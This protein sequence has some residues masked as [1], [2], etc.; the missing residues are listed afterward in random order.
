MALHPAAARK[1]EKIVA[2][3]HG[4]IQV[5]KVEPVALSI[6]R[7]RARNATASRSL[8]LNCC[9]VRNFSLC[10]YSQRK[11]HKDKCQSGKCDA[12]NHSY[13]LVTTSVGSPTVPFHRTPA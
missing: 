12:S 6:V 2:G 9:A 3:I 4:A 13:S 10:P 5:R 7:S 11:E 1:F 8:K